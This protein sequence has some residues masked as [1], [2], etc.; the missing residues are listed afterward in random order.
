MTALKKFD[1]QRDIVNLYNSNYYDTNKICKE[2]YN[3]TDDS[4]LYAISQH[5]YNSTYMAE[6]CEDDKHYS[7]DKYIVI[8]VK[9]LIQRHPLDITKIT[10]TEKY[11]NRLKF[12]ILF[13]EVIDYHTLFDNVSLINDID[14]VNHILS[15]ASDLNVNKLNIDG[16]TF[17]FNDFELYKRF[18]QVNVDKLIEG[19]LYHY[20]DFTII[21]NVGLTLLDYLLIH[22][23]NNCI[24]KFFQINEFDITKNCRWIHYLLHTPKDDLYIKRGLI[25]YSILER[26]DYQK[27]L[28]RV[29]LNYTYPTV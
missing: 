19:L 28:Y 1:L 14:V 3:Y 26:K 8:Y 21:D 13:H 9:I 2:L 6:R 20:Y 5:I 17:L 15:S 23:N 29:V 24:S 25:F 16:R 12:I 22:N 7:N 4:L 18:S 10:C 11:I 27:F